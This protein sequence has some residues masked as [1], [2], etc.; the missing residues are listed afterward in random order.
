MQVD[1]NSFGFS[2][3]FAICGGYALSRPEII[4]DFTSVKRASV[5]EGVKVA[6]ESDEVIQK[7]ISAPILSGDRVGA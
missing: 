2:E 1:T 7:I 5:F 6:A 3:L 4:N